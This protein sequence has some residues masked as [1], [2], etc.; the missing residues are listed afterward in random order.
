MSNNLQRLARE[1]PRC[2]DIVVA[3]GHFCFEVQRHRQ[4]GPFRAGGFCAQQGLRVV[5]VGSAGDFAPGGARQSR[6]LLRG[7]VFATV[8]RL[9]ALVGGQ[10]RA[11]GFKG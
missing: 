10:P 8:G 7:C 1:R 11:I 6:A 5:A 9:E 2:H 4:F 3:Q